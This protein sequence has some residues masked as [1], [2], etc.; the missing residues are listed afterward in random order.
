MTRLNFLLITVLLFLVTCK[1]GTDKN[2]YT[3][4]LELSLAQPIEGT[5]SIGGAYALYPLVQIWAD[6]FMALHKGVN[7]TITKD[8]TGEGLRGLNSGK[9]DLAMVSKEIDYSDTTLEA[10]FINV[11]Q[12]AVVP[13][14]NRNN[15]YLLEI[16]EKGLTPQQLQE[17]YI[18]GNRITWGN[19]LGKEYRNEAVIYT[20][21]DES[22]AAE[23]WAGFFWKKQED[24]KGPLRNG[25]SD[26]ELAQLFIKAVR[27]KPSEH[28]LSC[29]P[30]AKVEGRMSAI[31]G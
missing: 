15:P 20:R 26:G 16:E 24:L 5:L 12:D 31:G 21:Y 14:T 28:N 13:V 6:S 23:V 11:A 22:G 1:T 17:L 7:I 30:N 9:Y 8:G 4:P 25:C 2:L 29:D 10:D 18:S 27:H 3:S 19:L